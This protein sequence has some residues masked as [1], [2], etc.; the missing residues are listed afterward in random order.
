MVRYY[1][2]FSGQV[3]GVGFRFTLYQ[4]SR[5]RDITGWVR[6]RYDGKVEAQMQGAL[7]DILE[8]I[9][10]LKNH[11]HYI[12]IDDYSMKEIAPIPQEKGFAIKY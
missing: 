10:E 2:I 8:V 3:Q 11:S 7:N 12:E 4:L 5:Q 6:N 1:I 9:N